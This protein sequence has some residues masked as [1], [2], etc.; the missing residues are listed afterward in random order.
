M[1]DLA[2]YLMGR[3][4]TH[5]LEF[6]PAIRANALITID[7]TNRLLALAKGA[8]VVITPRAGGTL[9]NSGWR[10][11]SLNATTQ[12]ASATSLHMTGEAVDLY[13]PAGV[14]DGWCTR[15]ADTV[16]KSLGLWLEH[17]DF[18]P[19]WCHLQCRPPRSG[20]RIF[21]PR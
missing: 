12:G 7:I 10:P 3:D 8:G 20:N 2:E 15:V 21:R 16:L 19:G 5:A 6:S 11:P 13:D 18:T 17:P 1:I 14:I 9:V 4:V